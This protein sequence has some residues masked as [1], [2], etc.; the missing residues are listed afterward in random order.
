MNE[1]AVGTIQEARKSIAAKG[2]KRID[3]ITSA[4][5]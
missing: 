5:R 4:E 3:S 1:T 2:Q